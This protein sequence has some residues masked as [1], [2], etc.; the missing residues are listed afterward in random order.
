MS[1]FTAEV[2]FTEAEVDNLKAYVSS[3]LSLP[4]EAT[5]IESLYRLSGA[6]IKG[7]GA[8]ELSEVFQMVHNNASK[9]PSIEGDMIVLMD[10]LSAFAD[11]FQSYGNNTLDTIEKIPG[12]A[13]FKVEIADMTQEQVNHLP[14]RSMLGV[15]NSALYTVRDLYV[16]LGNVVRSRLEAINGITTRISDFKE[17]LS[18]K[19]MVAVTGKIALCGVDVIDRQIKDLDER[20]EKAKRKEAEAEAYWNRPLNFFELLSGVGEMNR[21]IKGGVIEPIIVER[22]RLIGALQDKDE[23]KAILQNVRTNLETIETLVTA[24]LDA[25]R[26]MESMWIMTAGYADNSVLKINNVYGIRTIN[27]LDLTQ[28][29]MMKDWR[30]VKAYVQS[31]RPAFCR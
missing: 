8:N 25:A 1:E 26:Q 14:M 12:Y 9:W 18:N 20:L 27:T 16:A 11:D 6:N 29:A 2:V 24:A 15:D 30:T 13:E 5:T 19:V 22:N 3:A 17:E 31:L 4:T 7:L 10:N 21:F 23:V 28:R